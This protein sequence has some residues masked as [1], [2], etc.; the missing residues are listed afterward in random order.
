MANRFI[1]S[2]NQK[3]NS[4]GQ[5]G[6]EGVEGVPRQAPITSNIRTQLRPQPSVRKSNV[7]PAQ[8]NRLLPIAAF[9]CPASAF[10]SAGSDQ[11]LSGI[12]VPSISWLDFCIQRYI[13]TL[14]CVE[15]FTPHIVCDHCRTPHR[16]VHL[17][18]ILLVFMPLNIFFNEMIKYSLSHHKLILF[19][20]VR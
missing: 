3:G 2:C 19:G 4:A 16:M 20:G 1:R 17:L 18:A 8:I 15:H 5:Q 7:R 12:F 9:N 6:V 11:G 14:R 13:R 10:Q